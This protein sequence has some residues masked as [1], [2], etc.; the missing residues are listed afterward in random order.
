[1]SINNVIWE[2]LKV[3]LLTNIFK[4]PWKFK[5]EKTRMIGEFQKVRSKFLAL[6]GHKLPNLGNLESFPKEMLFEQ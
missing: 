1:M 3:I 2:H 5:D 4:L 6:Y